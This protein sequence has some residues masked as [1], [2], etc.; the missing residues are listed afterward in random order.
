MAI[1]TFTKDYSGWKKDQV[2]DNCPG[3]LAA[4]LI[5]K[6]KVAKLGLIVKTKAKAKK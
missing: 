2:W 6:H 4:R 1:I 3:T 5:G